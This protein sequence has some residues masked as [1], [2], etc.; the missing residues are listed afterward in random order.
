MGLRPTGESESVYWKRARDAPSLTW[1]RGLLVPE[2]LWVTR[3][4]NACP[5]VSIR[6]L[7]PTSGSLRY[8]GITPTLVG[9]L[10]RLGTTASRRVLPRAPCRREAPEPR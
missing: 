9:S 4:P 10:V 1:N 5:P 7:S 3:E 8:S 6:S 2:Q